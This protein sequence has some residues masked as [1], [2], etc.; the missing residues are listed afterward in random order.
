MLFKASIIV[1]FLSLF[2]IHAVLHPIKKRR[3][4]DTNC[5]IVD[6]LSL[7]M[8]VSASLS[9]IFNNPQI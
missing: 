3:K 7:I 9:I 2:I 5:W 1:I 6:I 4:L 8:I